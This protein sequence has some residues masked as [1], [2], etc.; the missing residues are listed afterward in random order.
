M[1]PLY[2]FW[3]YISQIQKKLQKVLYNMYHIK[4]QRD[5]HNT[6][7][8]NF[9]Y[10]HKTRFKNILNIILFMQWSSWLQHGMV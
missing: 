4:N 2:N 1:K 10:V 9:K 8:F 7:K 6:D 3:T 5:V